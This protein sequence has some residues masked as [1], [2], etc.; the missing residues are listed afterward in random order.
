MLRNMRDS[1]DGMSCGIFTEDGSNF[2]E[3]EER[4]EMA[5]LREEDTR[6]IFPERELRRRRNGEESVYLVANIFGKVVKVADQCLK[7]P[8]LSSPSMA[9]IFISTTWTD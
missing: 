4:G 9:L 7:S 2:I 8:K 5:L 1:C 6:L 3:D